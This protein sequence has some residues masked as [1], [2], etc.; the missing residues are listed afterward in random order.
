[1]TLY[2]E[3]NMGAAGDMLASALL[4]LFDDKRIVVDELNNLSIPDTEIVYEKKM[5]AGVSGTHLK[6]LIKGETEMPGSHHDSHHHHRKLSDVFEIVEALNVSEKVKQDVKAVYTIVAEAEAKVHNAEAGEVHF[7]ELGMLDA[8]ADI[9][10]C[11]FLIDK[12]GADRI[13]CSPI[14]VGNG[15][16]KCAHGVLPVPA[17]ATAE[18]LRGIPYYKSETRT[19]LCTPTG[20]A[21]LKYYADEFTDAPCFENVKKIGTGTGTKELERANIIRVFIFEEN[22]IA[23]LSC[24]V[25]DMTGEEISY[26]ARK[27]LNEGALDSFV[28]PIFMKKGRP[29][30]MFTVL[31]RV[32]ECDRFAE[33]IFKH[34]STIG[35]R[36]YLPGRYTLGRELTE[37]NGALIKRSE[38]YGVSRVKIEFEDI[39]KLADEKDISVFEARK[40]LESK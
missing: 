35:I 22:V 16:V 40:I 14:N 1:M 8:V 36:K 30:Y 24:N 15:S 11:A 13:I 23:E 17:P 27:M 5:Q 4:D 37:E 39:K 6:M 28:T 25:D 3:C 29:A 26:A 33:L 21:V 19:E 7:H 38:G 20:A 31:C 18:I 10:C 9:T 12:L 32:G 34:T 2:F